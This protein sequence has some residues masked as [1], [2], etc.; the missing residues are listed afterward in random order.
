MIHFWQ[1]P[2]ERNYIILDEKLRIIILNNLKNEK[3]PTKVIRRFKRTKMS[4]KHII[5]ISKKLNIPLEMFE[6]NIYWIGGANSKGIHYPKLPFNFNSREGSRFIAAIINDGC[7]TKENIN[8]HSYGRLMYDNFDET[9]RESVINDYLTILGGEPQDIAFRDNDNKKYLEF[10]SVARD[11]VGLII[12]KGCKSENNT[13]IPIFIIK[14]KENM[15]GWIEQT[16]ADEGEVKYYPKKYR[17]A[18]VWRR[19]LD[20]SEIID[21]ENISIT[22]LKKLPLELQIKIKNK[23][24]NLIDSEKKILDKFGIKYSIYCLEIYSTKNNKVRL[25]TQISITKRENLLR[26]RKLIKIPSKCKDKKFYDICK[27]FKRYKEPLR[28]KKVILKLGENNNTFNSYDLKNKMNYKNVNTSIKWL[29]RFEK[30]GLIKK[31]K[32]S[33]YGNGFY[34][35]PAIYALKK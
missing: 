8:Y 10:N 28:I 26:L 4:I 24:F 34:R 18:I 15:L 33:V 11:T 31:I 32:E 14:N 23:K 35:K 9:I 3:F 22:S 29:R 30:E 5:E 6:K 27:E 17:R 12:K 13:E 25:R 7:L 2:Q 1:L 19:S 21:Q 16:I 20:I